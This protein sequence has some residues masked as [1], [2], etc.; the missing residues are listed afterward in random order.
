MHKYI[1]IVQL[2][3]CWKPEQIITLYC[4]GMRKVE[5]RW[6]LISYR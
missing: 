2:I 6:R 1:G 3:D 4:I 5:T